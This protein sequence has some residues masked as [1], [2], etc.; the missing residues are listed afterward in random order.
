MTVEN[1]NQFKKDLEQFI[2]TLNYW[3]L[4]YYPVLATDGV[5]YFCE[6]A[7]SYW[8]FSEIAHFVCHKTEEPFVVATITANNTDNGRCAVLK[9]DDGNNNELGGKVID[10]TDLPVG[11]WKFFVFNNPTQR[12][13]MLPSEY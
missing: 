6:T 8:L 7:E 4:S 11:E 9:F 12:V 13:V 2:G 10:Y 3:K 1:V 5:A